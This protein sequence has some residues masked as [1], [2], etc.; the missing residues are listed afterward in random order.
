M[1]EPP[2]FLPSLQ[3]LDLQLS[4]A[5]MHCK[6]QQHNRIFSLKDRPFQHF[7]HISTAMKW[8]LRQ[9]LS[10]ASI[11]SCEFASTIHSICTNC[12]E[13][14]LQSFFHLFKYQ[15]SFLHLPFTGRQSTKITS[16]P[17]T[18]FWARCLLWIHLWEKAPLLQPREDTC[19]ILQRVAMIA[20]FRHSSPGEWKIT[21]ST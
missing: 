9:K 8:L 15:T 10:S 3:V 7:T 5:L 14:S 11:F 17:L 21:I 2:L 20:W 4:T 12:H 16:P 1:K 18:N 19:L 13:Q 6:T